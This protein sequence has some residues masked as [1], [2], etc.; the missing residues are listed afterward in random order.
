MNNENTT[1][2]HEN[3]PLL[4]KFK[5]I[6]KQVTIGITMTNRKLVT[7]N[8]NMWSYKFTYFEASN[9]GRNSFHHL[10]TNQELEPT[11]HEVSL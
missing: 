5:L 1:I 8:N 3:G 9:F 6:H 7:H 10:L 2:Y 11:E 4:I